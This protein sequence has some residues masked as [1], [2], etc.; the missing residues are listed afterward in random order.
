MKNLFAAFVAAVAL[1]AAGQSAQAVLVI[2]DFNAPVAGQIVSAGANSTVVNATSVAGVLGGSRTLSVT[3]QN[4]SGGQNVDLSVNKLPEGQKDFLAYNQ[5]FSFGANQN[6]GAFAV[7]YDGDTNTLSD[8]TTNFTAD[9][10]QGGQN[11]YIDVQMIS[12]ATGAPSFGPGSVSL[13]IQI[14]T[15]GTTFQNA[16]VSSATVFVPNNFGGDKMVP[17]SSFTGTADF[18]HVN[19]FRI[20]AD[21]GAGA[22]GLGIGSI[23]ATTPEPTSLALLGLGGI[24]LLGGAIRCRRQAQ[25][26]A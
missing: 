11:S 8:L 1:A 12:L 6:N 25:A 19:G 9:L 17:F 5:P 16:A 10:T 2:D 13:L 14:F 15:G 20:S 23:S 7:T 24:G 22:V 4:T 26:A 3:N 18:S 21:P